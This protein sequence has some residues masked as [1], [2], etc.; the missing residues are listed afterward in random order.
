MT[1]IVPSAIVMPVEPMISN[2]L[3]PK[4]STVAIAMR[5]VAMLTTEVM[6]VMTN[7]SL[8]EKPTAC[9]RMLE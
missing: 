4:R 1:A 3:R 8:S 2:G 7:E 9:H 6:T 5:V